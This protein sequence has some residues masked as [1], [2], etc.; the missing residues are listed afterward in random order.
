MSGTI[1]PLI[2]KGIISS[3]CANKELPVR[4]DY[5]IIDSE[6]N[7]VS[8]ETSEHEYG[9]NSYNGLGIKSAEIIP[10]TPIGNYHNKQ[11]YPKE[12]NVIQI[13]NGNCGTIGLRFNLEQLKPDTPLLI[14][15]GEL[16]GCT[17]AFAIKDNYFYAFHCGQFGNNKSLWKTSHEGVETIIN[18]HLK[19]AD[20]HPKAKMKFDNQVL[21]EHF[22]DN[23]D[24]SIIVFC[25][26]GENTT[27]NKGNVI[28]F[29]YNKPIPSTENR[30][31]RV[32]N[33]AVVLL[34]LNGGFKI[35]ALGDDMNI[36][37]ESLETESNSNI[38]SSLI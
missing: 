11:T 25:G 29:D 20:T 10:G 14:H 37:N 18:A 33:A 1:T 9:V 6:H 27:S 23:F 19:L 38:I 26:H 4:Y 16:S 31:S 22:Q 24:S 15:G 5:V 32:A 36:D 8:R 30:K 17:M 13:D 12:L 21:V 7:R 2:G 3:R 28:T 35:T 34:K